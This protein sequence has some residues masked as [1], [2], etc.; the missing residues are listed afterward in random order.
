MSFKRIILYSPYTNTFPIPVNPS[1]VQTLTEAIGF[2]IFV[3]GLKCGMTVDDIATKVNQLFQD[4]SIPV[5]TALVQTMV[6]NGTLCKV[7]PYCV[8]WCNGVPHIPLKYTIN[9][10]V[11]RN[12]SNS[13]LV[14]F[15]VGL[16]GGTRTTSNVF[17]QTFKPYTNPVPFFVNGSALSV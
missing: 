11:D 4:Y 13:A 2:V 6:K 14:A 1:Q 15:L 16:A 10:L 3:Y 12:P 8:N 7:D 17:N 5:T 9:Y